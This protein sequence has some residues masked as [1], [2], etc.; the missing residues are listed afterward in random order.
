VTVLEAKDRYTSGHSQRVGQYSAALGRAT[1]LS[2]AEVLNRSAQLHDIGKI[3][4]HDFILKKPGKLTDEERRLFNTHPSI[5]EH[6][7]Q[8][9]DFLKTARPLIRHHHERF[10]GG[11]YPDGLKGDQIPRLVR[12][13]TIADSYDAMTSERPYRPA[14]ST[15][16]A[17]AEIRRCAGNQFDKDLAEA[18]CGEVVPRHGDSAAG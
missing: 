12:I 11:G 9:L 13:I 4:V 18:F 6:L 7:V 5:G 2:E 16:T 1:G 14:M 15:E 3:A 8:T 10:D 17:A